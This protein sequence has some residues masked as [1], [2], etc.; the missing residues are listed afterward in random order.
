[1]GD[2]REGTWPPYRIETPRLLLRPWDPPDAPALVGALARNHAHLAA[3]MPW[4]DRVPTL[5]EQ[6]ERIR[7]WR[8]A[9]DTDRDVILGVFQPG[10]GIVGGT[11]LH[12][13]I[14]GLGREIGYWVDRDHQGSGLVTEWCAALVRLAIEARGVDR[15]E[16]HCDPANT[17]SA[18]V[19]R[20]LGFTHEATLP[21][22]TV[23]V[24]GRLRDTSI[25]TLYDDQL[26]ASPCGGAVVRAW[27][28]AGRRLL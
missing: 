27:D 18:A 1:M 25:W 17:R 14:G 8:A 15:V 23:G 20:R 12:D 10:G 3:W 9:F 6:L 24:D 4:A 28:G 5:S 11:G 19:A 13:R 7:G 22:R 26:A 16:I 2:A 21:R